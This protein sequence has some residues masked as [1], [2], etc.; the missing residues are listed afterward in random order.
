MTSTPPIPKLYCLISFGWVMR[1]SAFSFTWC[2]TVYVGI[3][4]M[5]LLAILTME[6]SFHLQKYTIP[7]LQ[8]SNVPLSLFFISLIDFILP[9]APRVLFSLTVPIALIFLSAK[10][11]RRWYFVKKLSKKVNASKDLNFVIWRLLF[12]WPHGYLKDLLNSLLFQCKLSYDKGN[13]LPHKD[14]TVCNQIVWAYYVWTFCSYAAHSM[15]PLI[16]RY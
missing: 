12:H 7:S 16:H 9:L 11:A 3:C 4:E 10:S 2:F 5:K 14:T 8:K 1:A 15:A 6:L 13:H